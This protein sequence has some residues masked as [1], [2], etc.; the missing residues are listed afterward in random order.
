MRAM[1]LAAGAVLTLAACS[2]NNAANDQANADVNA[3]AN[4]N[5]AADANLTADQNATGGLDANAATN[6]AQENNLVKQDLNTNDRDTNLANG[7]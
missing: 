1:I 2:G 4:D 3:T 7:L 5:L 6:S